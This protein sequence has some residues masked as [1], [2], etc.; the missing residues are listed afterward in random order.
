MIYG[1]KAGAGK[2]KNQ[3]VSKIQYRC[4]LGNF[5]R[6]GI[7]YIFIFRKLIYIYSVL[8]L[9]HLFIDQPTFRTILYKY[10]IYKKL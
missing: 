7:A 3:S 2:E 4:T 6:H 9:N 1:G 5:V 8:H 10:L